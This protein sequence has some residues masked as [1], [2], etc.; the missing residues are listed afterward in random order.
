MID[1]ILD[2]ILDTTKFIYLWAWRIK[3]SKTRNKRYKEAQN[4]KI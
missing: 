2:I 3:Y 4:K 1:K